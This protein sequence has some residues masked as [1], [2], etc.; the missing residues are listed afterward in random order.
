[1]QS[2]KEGSLTPKP[3]DPE[4]PV[5]SATCAERG[6]IGRAGFEVA[7]YAFET[8][9]ERVWLCSVAMPRQCLKAAWTKFNEARQS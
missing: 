6:F 4:A 8:K 7:P 5:V 9:A 1:V 2:E 3:K